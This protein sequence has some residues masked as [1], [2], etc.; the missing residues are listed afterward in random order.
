MA[1]GAIWEPLRGYCGQLWTTAANGRRVLC[2]ETYGWRKVVKS[3]Q[4]F[5]SKG[6]DKWKWRPIMSM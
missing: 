3:L 2:A 6:L 5:L 1:P 4:I